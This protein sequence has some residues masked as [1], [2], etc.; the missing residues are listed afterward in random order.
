VQAKEGD[1]QGECWASPW[2]TLPLAC[3]SDDSKSSS[4]EPVTHLK[5]DDP[6]YDIARHQIVEVAGKH[7]LCRTSFLIVCAPGVEKPLMPPR[8][9]MFCSLWSALV[10]TYLP[11]LSVG[12]FR[13]ACTCH[14]FL[15]LQTHCLPLQP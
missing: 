14:C 3:S 10:H 13:L 7:A 12:R 1:S 11:L 8:K 9:N 2:V 5:W 4:P 15:D 6:Y